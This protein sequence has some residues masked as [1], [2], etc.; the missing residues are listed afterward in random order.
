MGAGGKDELSA[1]RLGCTLTQ[2]ERQPQGVE[3]SKA[4][5]DPL[6]RSFCCL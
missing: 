4:R 6:I 2:Q 3:K 1:P 5:V